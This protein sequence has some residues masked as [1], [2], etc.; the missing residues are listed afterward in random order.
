MWSVTTS[1]F[2]SAM[3]RSFALSPAF[4]IFC[5]SFWYFFMKCLD[6]PVWDLN[7]LWSRIREMF[8]WLLDA[9]PYPLNNEKSVSRK[10]FSFLTLK[11]YF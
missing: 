2:I 5:E 9:T 10:E 6:P 11:G 4:V 3:S 7:V 8:V 1:C